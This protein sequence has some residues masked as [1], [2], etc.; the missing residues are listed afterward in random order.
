M[1]RIIL[2]FVCICFASAISNA[3]TYS[4]SS[5]DVCAAW[6]NKQY[7]FT[8]TPLATIDAT[9]SVSWLYCGPYLNSN[10]GNLFMDIWVD[11]AWVDL[12]NTSNSGNGCSWVTNTFTISAGLLNDAINSNGGT[13]LIQGYITDG[14]AAGFGCNCC[15]DPCFDATLTYH[16]AINS[17]FSASTTQTCVDGAVTFFNQTTGP[18]DSYDWDFGTDA[19]P[20]TAVGPGPH[21]VFWTSTGAKTITLTAMDGGNTDIETKTDYID[22]GGTPTSIIF[23]LAS[24]Q[25]QHFTYHE[26]IRADQ[27][28]DDNNGGFFIIGHTSGSSP[29]LWASRIDQAGNELWFEV[30]YSGENDLFNGAKVDP[31]GNLFLVGQRNADYLL[32]KVDL[33]G[34]LI[35]TTTHDESGVDEARAVD[36]D[37]DG[38]IYV[39]G[40]TNNYFDATTVKFDSAGN[41]VYDVSITGAD[42]NHGTDVRFVNGSLYMLSWGR[43]GAI[44]ADMH[45]SKYEPILGIHQWTT[46]F[47]G[48]GFDTD[49]AHEMEFYG[50]DVFIMG[51]SDQGADNGWTIVQMGQDGSLGWNLDLFMGDADW[52]AADRFDIDGDG[53]LFLASTIDDGPDQAVKLYKINGSTGAEMWQHTF[54]AINET[55]LESIDVSANDHVFMTC[56]T[57]NNSGDWNLAVVEVEPTPTQLWW[58]VYDGCGP[59]H[60]WARDVIATPTNDVI[61]LG[62]N[63]QAVTVRYGALVDPCE[64]IDCLGCTDPLACNYEPD[65]IFEDGLCTYPGCN[66]PDACNFDS[67]AGCDDGSCILTLATVLVSGGAFPGEVDWNIY[68]SNNNLVLSGGA[69]ANTSFC[70]PDDCYTIEY[71]DSFGDGWDSTILQI[72][73]DQGNVLF[74]GSLATGSIGSEIFMAGSA[75]GCT[76]PTACNYSPV[77]I[78]DDGSCETSC[79]GCTDIAAC[80]Y[81]PLSTIDDGSC[82]LNNCDCAW[83]LNN[84]D[85]IDTADLLSF[86]AAYGYAPAPCSMADFDDDGFVGASDLLIFLTVFGIDCP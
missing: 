13:V 46:A 24:E 8:A 1:A 53:N 60:D 62:D 17:N 78:C 48:A 42:A 32:M 34:N 59:G 83:D 35:W 28:V 67:E 76:D 47:N 61:I 23:G 66:N 70:M 77:A 25:W 9:M 2:L 71:L 50:S 10:S 65:A 51:K 5:G 58:G 84:D 82:C 55:W 27:I 26:D 80:N 85:T 44:N 7:T 74:S 37:P 20:A 16:Y 33:N 21:N 73:D 57:F 30:F 45:L 43:S 72:L 52:D 31:S 3:Q 39:N 4:Q 15:A 18:Q 63:I 79:L 75:G 54:D 81:D 19:V 11:G 14:C 36:V 41:Y 40:S 86:L 56:R 38:N 22:V 69:P 64:D 68:D 12:I 6:T 49:E 29:S